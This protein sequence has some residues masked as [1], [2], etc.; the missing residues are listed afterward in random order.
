MVGGWGDVSPISAPIV[1][2]RPHPVASLT[3]QQQSVRW[4]RS[5]VSVIALALALAFLPGR[6]SIPPLIESDYCYLL[7][8]ADRLYSGL[9]LT[10]LQP[11]AP[12][13]PWEWRY[14]W[15]FLTQWPAGYPILIAGL[16]HLFRCTSIEACRIVSIVG[17]AAALV[18]WFAFL[19][20]SVPSGVTGFLLAAVAGASCLSVG[21]LVNPSTDLILIATLPFVLL[22][23]SD[24]LR[25]DQEFRR[26]TLRLAL[27][28]LLAGGLFWFRYASL[29]V[30]AAIGLLIIV[31]FRRN[32]VLLSSLAAFALSAGAP[33]IAL[34][35]VNAAYGPANHASEQFNLGSKTGFDVS[36]AALGR[37]W[38]MFTDLGFYSHKPLAHWLFAVLPFAVLLCLPLKPV[39]CSLRQL[40]GGVELRLALCVVVALLGMIVCAAGFFGAK[41]DYIGLERYYLP[42]RPL[43]FLIFL[44]PLMLIPR[45]AVRATLC[46][47]LVSF[48]SW[49]I[50]Q[51]WSPTYSRWVQANRP[52][53]PSGAWSRPF[54][55]NSH[56]LCD[57]LGALGD[58]SSVLV[59]SN[60]HEYL[61]LETGIAILPIP[62]SFEALI[63]MR[64]R[65]KQIR[66]VENPLPIFVLHPEN[67]WRD[68]W[69]AP[70]GQIVQEFGL[71]PYAAAPAEVR[72]YIFAPT[73]TRPPPTDHVT[74]TSWN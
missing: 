59:F 46:L 54:E 25:T 62:S 40:F 9:G 68:Y 20:R 22:L 50:F 14:D 33:I 32:R 8:A 2:P 49:T 69:I 31:E 29:F 23:V 34:V 57:W 28:G 51:E 30:P 64:T 12:L 74:V 36:F 11:V 5:L 47:V 6:S 63:E 18:G 72:S 1:G 60:F 61:A 42:G 56:I 35:A 43:Y 7:I 48:A 67:L 71:R 24:G 21:L 13:Q 17:C 58:D 37:A 19:R 16:R 55:P 10:S 27:A 41:F 53:T 39:R 70:P 15:G 26:A 73:I 45:R 66:G 38:W 65:S 44:A 52:S 4:S 3:V